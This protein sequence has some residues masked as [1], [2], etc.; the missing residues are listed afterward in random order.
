LTVF[1]EDGDIFLDDI[2]SLFLERSIDRGLEW[3]GSYTR[4]SCEDTEEIGILIFISNLR[5]IYSIT[6][7]Q[8]GSMLLDEITPLARCD[9]HTTLWEIDEIRGN[10]FVIEGDQDMDP[11]CDIWESITDMHIIEIDPSLD[12]RLILTI[13]DH[14]IP[15]RSKR[16]CDDIHDGVHTETSRSGD[17]DAEACI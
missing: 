9:D 7:T 15:E 12:D 10:I 3:L 17:T 11:S 16:R 5:I 1:S 13:G 6:S 14:I 8:I 2:I 4:E